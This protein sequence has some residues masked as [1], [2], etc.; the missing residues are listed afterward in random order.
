MNHRKLILFTSFAYGFTWL[1]LLGLQQFSSEEPGVISTLLAFLYRWGPAIAAI[2]VAR[3][4]YGDP[5]T[6]LGLTSRDQIQGKWFFLGIAWA[7]L[8]LPFTVFLTWLLSDILGANFIGTLDFNRQR[9]LDVMTPE[10]SSAADMPS[11]FQDMSGGMLLLI[12]SLTQFLIGTSLFVAYTYGEELAWRGFLVQ[13]TK[14]LGFW[15]SNL[16]VGLVSG[17]WYAGVL[18]PEGEFQSDSILQFLTVFLFYVSV[19][20]PLSYFA[21][22][23]GTLLT[24]ACMQGIIMALA[25][26]FMVFVIVE[27]SSA[28]SGIIG[29]S[30]ILFSVVTSLFLS[31]RD[32]SFLSTF[33]QASFLIV[34][35]QKQPDHQ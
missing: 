5:L 23:S 6:Q 22:K 33:H 35:N 9:I 1:V 17:I 11:Y 8:L 10:G 28:W 26:T 18:F 31:F 25:G 13:E 32:P 4:M 14:S 7:T 30:G 15:K 19:S 34:P 2:L 29:L 27:E 3:R 12:T 24:P 20:F 21:R 16:F